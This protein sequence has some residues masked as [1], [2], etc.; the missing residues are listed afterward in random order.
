M[1]W[2]EVDKSKAGTTNNI[3]LGCIYRIPGHD[4]TD[5]NN[6]LLSI[7]DSIKNENKTIY[8]L[9]DYNIDITQHSA[10]P[11]TS[12]FIDLN[13]AH[14]FFPIITKPTR[15]TNSTA[16]LIDNIFTNS[17]NFANEFSGIIPS[18][19][20]DHFPIF[21]F[22]LLKRP[23]NKPLITMKCDYCGKNIEQFNQSLSD[24]DWS[25]LYSTGNAQDAYTILHDQGPISL[26]LVGAKFLLNI[27]VYL[28]LSGIG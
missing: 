23:I 20:S 27:G 25:S 22:N 26:R 5:F 6:K 4:I 17:T 24:I 19:I 13:F 28:F 9:G 7:F 8:H 3:L 18:D 2:I 21:Q 11:S 10:H 15:I 12:E 1:L 14:S 16:S